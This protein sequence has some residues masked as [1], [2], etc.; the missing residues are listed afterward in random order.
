MP[1]CAALQRRETAMTET[2]APTT[3]ATPPMA[4]ARTGP[5]QPPPRATTWVCPGCAL[6][7][8]CGLA[9]NV[10]D[11]EDGDDCTDDLC[12]PFVG[13]CTNAASADGA[14]CDSGFGQCQA[15]S[16]QPSAPVFSS[17]TK[18]IPV[19]CVGPGVPQSTLPFDLT[20]ATTPIVGGADPRAFTAELSGVDPLSGGGPRR[21]AVCGT[22]RGAGRL[23]LL[24]P[25]ARHGA[26]GHPRT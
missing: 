20:I 19:T 22:G 16:C 18:G 3:S 23:S 15:G 9:C 2:S 12:D 1:R 4:L 8:T 17:Q 24:L 6:S 5:S 21:S 14:V 7:S 25:P 10:L 26:H 11:C 13:T